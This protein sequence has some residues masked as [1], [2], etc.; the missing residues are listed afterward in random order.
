MEAPDLDEL[1]YFPEQGKGQTDYF[2]FLGS[3][4]LFDARLGNVAQKHFK[5][6]KVIQEKKPLNQMKEEVGFKKT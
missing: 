3:N 1:R 6:N 2:A 4:W 5:F